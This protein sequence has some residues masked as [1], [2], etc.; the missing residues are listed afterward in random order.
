MA[1]GAFIHPFVCVLRTASSSRSRTRSPEDVG[2][3][4]FITSFGAESDED[5]AAGGAYGPSL[6]SSTGSNKSARS[7]VNDSHS[8]KNRHSSWSVS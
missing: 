5:A 6:P 2:K 7:S 1:Q 3:V 8:D 4:K